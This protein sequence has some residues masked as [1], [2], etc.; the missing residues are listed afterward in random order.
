MSDGAR[1]LRKHVERFNSGVRSGDF[2]P[3]RPRSPTTRR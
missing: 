1:V 3:W 2:G